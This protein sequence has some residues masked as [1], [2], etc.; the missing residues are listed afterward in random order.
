MVFDST[1]VT[2]GYFQNLANVWTAA[3]V[4]Y[5][6]IG[7]VLFDSTPLPPGT[8]RTLRTSGPPCRAPTRSAPSSRSPARST[9][10]SG[11][12]WAPSVITPYSEGTLV[13]NEA[14]NLNYQVAAGAWALQTVIDRASYVYPNGQEAAP[15]WFHDHMLGATRLNVYAGI[16]GGYVITEPAVH[17]RPGPAP[18]RPERRG[19]GTL[20]ELTVPLIIQDRMFDTTGQLFFPNVGINPEHPFWVPEFVGDVIVVNGKAWP[21]LNVQPKRY[22][23]LFLNG[24]NAR[25]YELYFPAGPSIWVIANDQGYL[26]TPQL[27]NPAAKV[28]N[29]LTMMPGERYEVIIDF[30]LFAGKNLILQNTARTPWVGGAVVN[31]NT[32]GRIMQF[33]VAPA[34]PVVDNSF[35]PAAGKAI[36]A[37]TSPLVRLSVEGGTTA[38]PGVTIHKTR[39]LT[40]NEVI[41]AGGPLEIL[42]NNTLY[43]GSKPRPIYTDPSR[44]RTTS[45]RSPAC[46]TPATTPSCRTR[47]KRKCGRSSTS[48]PTPTRCTR[49]WWRSRS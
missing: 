26:A 6:G 47:A 38:A 8:S 27:I 18:P 17:A 41:A 7:T 20:T 1:P 12:S 34:G 33:R 4:A 29:K 31:N 21:F 15:V 24:S 48:R 44:A 36:R 23:F 25:S 46:R 13:F 22:K 37:A 11:T 45:P 16:A 2:G 3:T 9:R 39:R 40:L 42:V 49:T 43:D 35:L 32:T 10:T 19:H 28:N 14:D 5:S 30:T